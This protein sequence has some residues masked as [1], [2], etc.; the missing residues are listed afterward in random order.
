MRFAQFNSTS[1]FDVRARPDIQFKYQTFGAFGLPNVEAKLPFFHTYHAT[2]TSSRS[3]HGAGPSIAW[4]GSTEIA[5][6]PDAGITFDWGANGALLFGKQKSRVR[7]HESGHYV[8]PHFEAGIATPSGQPAHYRTAYNHPVGGHTTNRNVIAPNLGGFAG[9][10][11]LDKNAKVSFGYR[12]DFFFNAMDVGI[13]KPKSETLGFFGPFAKI[14][15]GLG[16]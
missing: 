12:G 1:T 2:G 13:D 6:L 5:N 9:L 7:H 11:F 14:S 3:F 8:T 16:G 4:N 10:S 15:I